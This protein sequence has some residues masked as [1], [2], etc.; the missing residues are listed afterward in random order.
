MFSDQLINRRYFSLRERCLLIFVVRKFS[1]VEVDTEKQHILC[2][3][4]KST[5]AVSET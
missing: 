5:R 3:S 2:I 4:G 1:E